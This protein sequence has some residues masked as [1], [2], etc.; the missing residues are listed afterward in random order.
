MA[1]TD[2]SD[3][4]PPPRR[5]A[6]VFSWNGWWRL[7]GAALVALGWVAWR[8]VPDAIAR[9]LSVMQSPDAATAARMWM[10]AATR[11]AAVA[12]GVA[13]TACGLGVLALFLGRRIVRRPALVALVACTGVAYTML[14]FH[15]RALPGDFVGDARHFLRMAGEWPWRPGGWFRYRVLGP[16]IARALGS[17]PDDVVPDVAGYGAARGWFLLAL[18]SLALLGPALVLLLRDLRFGIAAQHLGVLLYLSSFALL[19]HSFNYALPDPLALLLLV[20]ACRAIVR[21]RDAELAVWLLLG[22]LTKEVVLFL[23]PVR[24]LWARRDGHGLD[25][26]AALRAT[27]P[28]LPAL[29]VFA[30]LRFRPDEAANYTGFV[31]GNAF[32]FPWRH[33]PDNVA[34]LYSPFAAGWALIAL[35]ALRPDRWTRAAL[36]FLAPCAF[37]LL[38]TDSGRMLVYL[39]P[40][41]IP[42]MLRAAGADARVP[43][44]GLIALLL[45]CLSMR[46]WEPFAVLWKVPLFVRR[47]LALLLA[48]V[49]AWL[50]RDVWAPP[51]GA[52][53]QRGDATPRS[54]AASSAAS[55]S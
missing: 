40:F 3:A 8:V 39:T 36:G 46:L 12:D 48:T 45:V 43:R 33:Q 50:V 42:A 38:F 11:P 25:V 37:S 4:H 55:A 26:P 1:G 52:A 31:A 44:R 21:G 19:Y 7:G 32:L 20:L 22:G 30:W 27:L 24:W 23:V 29:A 15:A 2:P 28:A 51:R 18:G 9:P 13:L 16:W 6:G 49:C 34:R 5:L 41:A 54:T 35:A 47:P 10:D 17:L 14:S 53:G